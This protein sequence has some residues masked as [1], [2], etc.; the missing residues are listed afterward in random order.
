MN[1]LSYGGIV[2]GTSGSHKIIDVTAIMAFLRTWTA[3]AMGSP[4]QAMQADCTAASTLFPST[5]IGSGQLGEPPPPL[6]EYS[7]RN[8]AWKAFAIYENTRPEVKL[9]DLV[10][11]VRRSCAEINGDGMKKVQGD[12]AFAG[13]SKWLGEGGQIYTK[14][15]Q[16]CYTFASWCGVGFNDLDF[17]WGR[18]RWVSTGNIGDDVFKN[19]VVMMHALSGNGIEAWIVLEEQEM[20]IP[21]QV[22]SFLRLLH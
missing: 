10:E 9:H 16:D 21:E 22:G 13:I 18:P 14:I 1:V 15:R 4:D 8:V 3:I 17:G 19:A 20:S 11:S 5:P 7:I 6:P 12:A 2:T